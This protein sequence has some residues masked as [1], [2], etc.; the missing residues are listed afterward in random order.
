MAIIFS[1]SILDL[2]TL[3]EDFPFAPYSMYSYPSRPGQARQNRYG[4]LWLTWVTGGGAELEVEP[5]HISPLDPARA[6]IGMTDLKQVEPKLKSLLDLAA[7][8]SKGRIPQLVA[9]RLYL[10]DPHTGARRLH[11]ELRTNAQ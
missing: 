11:V 7:K 3:R 9:A 5:W 10:V 4:G 8:N 1:V 2:W 6:L